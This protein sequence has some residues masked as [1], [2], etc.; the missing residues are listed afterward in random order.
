VVAP[1]SA[2][3]PTS[4]GIY[5]YDTS[6]LSEGNYEA[7]WEFID[8]VYG[9]D[10]ST[11]L[12]SIDASVSIPSGV[13][14]REIEQEVAPRVGPYDLLAAGSLS[15][16]SFAVIPELDSSLDTGQYEDLYM[17]RRGRKT[18]GTAVSGFNSADRVRIC[19]AY[20]A[21]TGRLTPD[22][23]WAVAPVE[24]EEIEFHH[25]HPERQLRRACKAGL[26][27]CYFMD[28]VAVAL[29][30]AASERNVTTSVVWLK[31][32][33]LVKQIEYSLAGSVYNPRQVPWWRAIRKGGNVW[34]RASDPYPQSLEITVMRPAS[35]YVNGA[36]SLV[37]PDDDEDIVNVDLNYAAAAGHVEAWRIARHRLQ[38]AAQT[39]LQATQKQ[40]AD[41]FTRLSMKAIHAF[42]QTIQFGEPLYEE[43]RFQ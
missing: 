40:A 12:F 15:D 27:R 14:L 4:A 26:K 28:R 39:G 2:I 34:L 10:Y 16:V 5:E 8:P 22:R 3:A 20:D 6:A 17:L 41:E 31:D 43:F 18:D 1:T 37:G 42:P 35:T 30:S 32:E 19:A 38:P 25:L 9:T 24:N 7:V 36:T 23:A 13:T 11:Q 21:A 33:M 29:T